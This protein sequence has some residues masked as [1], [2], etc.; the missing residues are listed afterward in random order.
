[1]SIIFHIKIRHFNP[2]N[3]YRAVSEKRE[4]VEWT[5]IIIDCLYETGLL[6]TEP[7]L[8]CVGFSE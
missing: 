3:A 7:E 6:A 5:I 4:K 2:S 1:M 8:L